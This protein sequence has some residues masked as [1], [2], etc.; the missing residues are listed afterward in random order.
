MTLISESSALADFCARQADSEFITVDT[1]F[2]RERTYWPQLCLVQVGGPEELAAVDALAPDLD[3]APLKALLLDPGALKVF[4]SARQ[5]L[6]IFYHLWGALPAPIFD[7]Q[8]AAMVCGFGE[9]V[10]YDTLARKLVGAKLDKASRFADW[11][12]RPLTARQLRYALSDVDHL[13]PIYRQLAKHLAKNRRGEWLSEEMALLT[14]PGTYD[15][16]P[17]NA[18]RRLK[19]R[20]SN[21]RYLAVLRSLAAWRE[22][23]A[24]RRDVPRGRV[25]RDEQLFDIAAHIPET[26]EALARS[27]GLNRE[28]ATGRFGRAILAAVQEGKAVP[29]EDCPQAPE[30]FEPPKGI[31]PMIDLLRVLLK[32]RCEQEDVAQRLVAST[33]DLELIAAGPSPDVP[34]L[35]G[36]RYEIFGKDALA[37]KEGRLALG[38]EGRKVRAVPV[39]SG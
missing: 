11:A 12:H 39:E 2:I 10:A 4:H 17:W 24:Q 19:T 22:T 35:K 31:G 28:M 29:D 38:I 7:T 6:E 21:P 20:S 32:M 26:P 23:E 16:D 1:E 33:S 25:L 36:W 8:V 3:L 15:T 13:R 14:D 37:L 18:W 27:R 5:D 30:R 34:A 9:S